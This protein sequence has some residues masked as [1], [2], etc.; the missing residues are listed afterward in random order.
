MGESCKPKHE[1]KPG[2]LR[3]SQGDLDGKKGVYHINVVDEVPSE[4]LL[5]RLSAEHEA[6]LTVPVFHSPKPPSDCVSMG[7]TA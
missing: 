6:G 7:Y 5:S 2:H 1:G 4:K 3:V